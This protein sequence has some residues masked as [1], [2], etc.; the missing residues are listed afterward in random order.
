MKMVTNRSNITHH[1]IVERCERLGVHFNIRMSSSSLKYL[2][3]EDSGR[4]KRETHMKH[5]STADNIRFKVLVLLII[6]TEVSEESR[7]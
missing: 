5:D 7:A 6:E 3:V 2:S 4:C 1:M